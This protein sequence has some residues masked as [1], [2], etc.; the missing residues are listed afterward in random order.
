M[1]DIDHDT[2]PHDEPEQVMVEDTQH[3][4]EEIDKAMGDSFEVDWTGGELHDP[5]SDHVMTSMIDVLQTLGVSAGDAMP[6][7]LW[8]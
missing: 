4:C 6:M 7:Q 2:T 5:D 3:F 8:L 1:A